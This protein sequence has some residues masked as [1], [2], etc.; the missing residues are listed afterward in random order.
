MAS[1]ACGSLL[2]CRAQHFSSGIGPLNLHSDLGETLG[3]GSTCFL[4]GTASQAL[5]T[6]ERQQMPH[7]QCGDSCP[8]LR[9]QEL[10]TG[11]GQGPQWDCVSTI[12]IRVYSN[13]LQP[14]TLRAAVGFCSPF[15]ALSVKARLG[16]PTQSLESRRVLSPGS[17]GTELLWASSMFSRRWPGGLITESPSALPR[18]L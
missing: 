9:S 18:C 11:G 1:W 13:A 17:Q 5:S 16:N 2:V 15:F 6:L 3:T 10:Q 12:E 14:L 7:H 4:P 8:T